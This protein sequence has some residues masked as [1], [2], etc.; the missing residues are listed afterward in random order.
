MSESSVAGPLVLEEP[1]GRGTLGTLWRA[2]DGLGRPV[3]AKRIPVCGDG[4]LVRLLDEDG[5][6]LATVDRPASVVAWSVVTDGRCV[7]LVMDLVAGGSWADRLRRAGSGLDGDE[8]AAVGTDVARTVAALHALGILHGDLKSSAVLFDGPRGEGARARLSDVGV[9]TR[10]ADADRFG[11]L[12][13]GT[14]GR[15]D[16]A[17]AAGHPFG[18]PSDVFALGILCAEMLLGKVPVGGLDVR[19]VRYDARSLERQLVGLDRL[20]PPA[21]ARAIRAATDPRPESRPTAAELAAALVDGAGNPALPSPRTI[22]GDGE[23]PRPSLGRGSGPVARETPGPR[24][25]HRRTPPSRRGGRPRRRLSD[26]RGARARL[27]RLRRTIGAAG[28]LVVMV[29]LVSALW[30]GVSGAPHPFQHR[31]GAPLAA[32]SG[33]G[34]PLSGGRPLGRADVAGSGCRSPVVQVGSELRVGSGPGRAGIVLRFRPA[35]LGQVVLGDFA[36]NGRKTPAVYQQR[37]GLVFIYLDWP[38]P[39]RPARPA[40]RVRTGVMGGRLT[41]RRRRGSPCSTVTVVPPKRP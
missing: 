38:R 5:A 9:A 3:A 30:R 28:G 6:R 1:I 35:V 16:P 17:V 24:P 32:C 34:S 10:F 37:T 29:L 13:H 4:D 14:V 20:G 7:V 19:S 8:V 11:P 12:V 33:G 18:P 23:T 41:V 36:C 15:L 25:L 26:Q 40:R 2:R 31:L 39:G 27:S 21:L 22:P